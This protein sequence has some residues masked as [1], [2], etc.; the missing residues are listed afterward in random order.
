MIE[1]V[2]FDIAGTTVNDPDLVLISLQEA[3]RSA[4]V[5]KSRDEIN[6]YMGITKP[7]AITQLLGADAHNYSVARIHDDFVARMLEVYRTHPDVR[8]I[9]GAEEVFVALKAKGIKIALDTGFDR[10]ICN[11]ILDRLG[12][13]ALFDATV[14]SDEVV[15]GRPFP[16]LVFRAM[17][18]T[19]TTN[20]SHVAKVGDTPSD[21]LEAANAEC[22]LSFGVL[23][24]THTREE[25]EIHPHTA[26]VSHLSEILP[27]IEAH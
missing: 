25:L 20:S 5:E 10:Q 15:R 13:N 23:Y 3:L 7:V 27:M 8:P 1:L 12:W 18:L 26:L 21:L 11:V 2:I 19:G 4:G 22:G 16:D 6:P 24:G 9:D 17:E 14:T